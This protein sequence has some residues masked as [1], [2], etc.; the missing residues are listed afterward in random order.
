M[1]DPGPFSQLL[2]KWF[3]Q[4]LKNSFKCS[5]KRMLSNLPKVTQLV[6][7]KPALSRSR[8]GKEEEEEEK[9][10]SEKTVSKWIFIHSDCFCFPRTVYLNLID[11]PMNKLISNFQE[12]TVCTFL[13]PFFS[14]TLNIIFISYFHVSF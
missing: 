7:E 1:C 13:P 6:S 11:T 10:F 2:K 8:A 12:E 14:F 5:R 4:C 3:S 9:Q